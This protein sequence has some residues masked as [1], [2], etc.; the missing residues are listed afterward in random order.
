MNDCPTNPTNYLIL[1]QPLTHRL[2]AP[3]LIPL[4]PLFD[5]DDDDIF[6]N[7]DDDDDD[8]AN[9][10]FVVDDDDDDDASKISFFISSLNLH[11][12]E[13]TVE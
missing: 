13:L 7:D 3:C 8:D 6:V 4:S 2:P 9:D 1:P 12:G 5:D 11:K 10:V